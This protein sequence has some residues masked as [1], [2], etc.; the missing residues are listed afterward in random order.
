M[1]KLWT[2]A[3]VLVVMVFACAA[4]SARA[5]QDD[6]TVLR[7]RMNGFNEVTP[8]LTDAS[9]LFTATVNGDHIDFTLTFSNLTGNPGAAHLHFGQRQVSGGVFLF[10]CGG[11]NQPACPTSTSG[12]ITGT[13]GATNVVAQIPDQGIP[14]GEFAPA[15]RAIRSGLTY[16]NM[17]TA[18]FPGGEIRGQVKVRGHGDD[19][20]D[21]RD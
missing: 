9:G 19:D 8:K 10:L 11:G 18:K 21:D 20:D 7:A 4:Y 16:A 1:K 17:H 14:A 2:S 12:T 6:A 5:D 13:A 15:L 3:V